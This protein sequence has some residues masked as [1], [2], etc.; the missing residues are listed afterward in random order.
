MRLSKRQL[1]RI[2]REERSRINRRRLNEGEWSDDAIE[3]AY[4]CVSETCEME[5]GSRQ[6]VADLE[7]VM[8]QF[9]MEGLL[10]YYVDCS[11]ETASE[12]VAMKFKKFLTDLSSIQPDL[13]ARCAKAFSSFWERNYLSNM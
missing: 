13:A 3:D 6:I 5:E 11:K 10:S 1:K 9:S 12:E 4:M 7:Y 2:I 8:E